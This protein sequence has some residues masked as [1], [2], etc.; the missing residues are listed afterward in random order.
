MAYACSKLELATVR[1]R[2][3][4]LIERGELIKNDI[5]RTEGGK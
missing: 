5:N 2:D 3:W 4:I 1:E